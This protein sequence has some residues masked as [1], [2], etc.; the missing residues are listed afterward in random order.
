MVAYSLLKEIISI[1]NLYYEG[2]NLPSS[3]LPNETGIYLEAFG[4]A[5]ANV[6]TRENYTLITMADHAWNHFIDPTGEYEMS[7]TLRK[8]IGCKF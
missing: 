1:H 6:K 2:N 4:E 3:L 8:T 5:R 7:K